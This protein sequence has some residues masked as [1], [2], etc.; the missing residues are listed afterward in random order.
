MAISLK[1]LY[2]KSR[3]HSFFLCFPSAQ[4]AACHVIIKKLLVNDEGI[5]FWPMVYLIMNISFF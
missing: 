3:N 1:L 5:T 4:Y 2:L